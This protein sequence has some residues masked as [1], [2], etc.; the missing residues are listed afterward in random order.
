[1]RGREASDTE[2]ERKNRGGKTPMRLKEKRETEKE[3][4][5]DRET[6]RLR[7]IET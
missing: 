7:D 5:T 3:R 6:G 4:R 1:M 2:D